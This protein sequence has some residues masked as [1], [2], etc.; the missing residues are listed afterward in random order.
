MRLRNHLLRW[1]LLPLAVV[2][3]VGFHLD[4]ARSIDQANEAKMLAILT[5]AQKKQ[6]EGMQGAKFTFPEG[7]RGGNRR[8]GGNN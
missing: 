8:P 6:F 4:Y 2:W 7:R 1:L 3:A 5:D